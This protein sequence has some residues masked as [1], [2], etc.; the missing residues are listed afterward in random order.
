MIILV[1][2]CGSSSIKYQLF[3]G[4]SS[5]VLV[6]GQ[7]SRIGEK[8]SSL[9]QEAGQAKL[10]KDIPVADHRSGFELIVQSLLDP[11]YGAIKNIAEVS[12]VGHRAVHGGS[13]FVAST[14]INEDVIAKME[15]C[16]P[17]AP[18]HNPHNLVGI[19]EAR[20]IFSRVPHVAV[21][22]TTFHQTMPAHAYLY[23]LPY[24]YYT[25]YSIRRYGFH[26]TS[27]RYIVQRAEVIL[28]KAM[29]EMKIIICH[30][31]NGV[32]IA[33][34]N[35]GKSVDT[36]LGFTP[37]PGVMMGTRS[38]DIDPGLIL[39][40]NRQMGLDID[41]IDYILNHE[42]GL[43]GISGVSNDMREIMENAKKG[44]E[45]CQLAQ[46]MFI[47]QVKKYIGAY[48]A[49]MGGIDALIF[50]AGIG[51]N[52]PLIRAEICKNMEFLGIKLNETKNKATIGVEQTI[53]STDAKVKVMVIPT[54][55]E[56][57]IAQD[58][59][60]IALPSLKKE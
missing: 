42:S 30:L 29:G 25:N 53:S 49:A 23:A 2:N 4:D 41:R 12:A 34:V 43:L 38:G 8:G 7:V 22:D 40:L 54:N 58:T 33:A 36:S 47:Y 39:Y 52:S 1:I 21:F 20:R 32:T 59:I 27:C 55:E 26:G 57:M 10:Q 15:A 19:R 46:E 5:D 9:K 3:D 6:K 11:V 60:A 31:G 48:A 37:I 17:L 18:L 16:I 56:L 14:I 44:N 51:E 50:T 13:M 45:R 28:R 24:N 35:K